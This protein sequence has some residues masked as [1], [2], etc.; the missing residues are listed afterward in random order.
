M[1]GER[2]VRMR[3]IFLALS[4]AA[5]AGADASPKDVPPPDEASLLQAWE[6]AQ[7]RSPGTEVLERTGDRRYRFKTSRFP[8][9]GELVVLNLLIEPLPL[10][11]EPGYTGTV[12]VELAGLPGDVKSRYVQ[13]FAR[14]QASHTLFYDRGRGGWLTAEAWREAR[15]KQ[16]RGA[17]GAEPGLW[18]FLSAN[19]FWIL[20]LVLLVVFLAHASRKATR[21]MKAALEVQKKVIDDQ[22]LSL[23][24]ARRSIELN[25]QANR[26]LE[27]IRDTLRARSQ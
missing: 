2:E 16:L 9:D 11:E 23:D 19:L 12:E 25:E 8:F 14:W 10:D 26:L 21:Q 3:G 6:T 4:L 13:S 18:G 1:R 24:M 5:G 15:T 22:Q 20:F 27:E 17:F 7:R